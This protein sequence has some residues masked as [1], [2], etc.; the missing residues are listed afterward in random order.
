MVIGDESTDIILRELI[1]AVDLDTSIFI[2]EH[3][4]AAVC[5]LD[6]QNLKEIFQQ[7]DL[8]HDGKISVED[9]ILNYRKFQG[10]T[11]INDANKKPTANGSKGKS[12]NESLGKECEKKGERPSPGVPFEENNKKR[13][14]SKN[15]TGK[16]ASSKTTPA[17]AVKC[18]QGTQDDIRKT[19]EY[20]LGQEYLD[21]LYD[22][23]RSRN[24]PML[25]E[26]LES[27]LAATVEGLLQKQSDNEK[28]DTALKRATEK[29]SA[30]A[31][32]LEVEME[33]QVAMLE[34]KIRDEEQKKLEEQKQEAHS[35]MVHAQG[36]LREMER[37]VKD[38]EDHIEAK[39]KEANIPDAI[40][41]EIQ[42][43][44][45][46]N[47]L[48][49][50]KLVEFQTQMAL[51]RTEVAQMKAVYDE[52][53]ERL[54]SERGAVLTCVSEQENLTRQLHLLHEANKRLHDTND[55]LRSAL[56]KRNSTSLGDESSV[57]NFSRNCMQNSFRS[58][59]GVR[60]S[61]NGSISN[62]DTDEDSKTSIPYDD[63]EGNPTKN[64]VNETP[65]LAELMAVDETYAKAKPTSVTSNSI[66]N[67][68]FLE[69]SCKSDK[70]TFIK[71]LEILCETNKRLGE[72][73]DELRDALGLLSGQIR[74]DHEMMRSSSSAGCQSAPVTP[75]RRKQPKTERP[76]ST[77]SPRRAMLNKS[78]YTTASS[79]PDVSTDVTNVNDDDKDNQ[80][81]R[82]T[83]NKKNTIRPI[84]QQHETN[85]KGDH[86]SHSKNRN[87]SSIPLESTTLTFPTNEKSQL[88][89]NSAKIK[90]S[91]KLASSSSHSGSSRVTL[92]SD[93]KPD[94][95]TCRT[96]R[97]SDESQATNERTCDCGNEINGSDISICDFCLDSITSAV[98]EI[99][100]DYASSLSE[101][102]EGSTIYT[103]KDEETDFHHFS[104][105][106]LYHPKR[107]SDRKESSSKHDKSIQ[108]AS[109]TFNE[110]D[111]KNE[112]TGGEAPSQ[113]L[114]QSSANSTKSVT[115]QKRGN[116]GPNL[117][118]YS[119]MIDS[120][121]DT[122]KERTD[123]D[124]VN[125]S[126]N[127]IDINPDIDK[128]NAYSSTAIIDSGFYLSNTTDNPS[129]S[130]TKGNERS[131]KQSIKTNSV[132]TNSISKSDSRGELDKC[133]KSKNNSESLGDANFHIATRTNILPD[134]E[135]S[136]SKRDTLQ[137]VGTLDYDNSTKGSSDIS[138]NM[139]AFVPDTR[140]VQSN[141]L[142]HHS[143]D[144]SNISQSTQ[145][146]DDKFDKEIIQT[147]SQEED[148]ILVKDNETLNNK[149]SE[150]VKFVLRISLSENDIRNIGNAGP[151]NDN[152][153]N[154]PPSHVAI[155][156]MPATFLQ[157]NNSTEKQNLD[158]VSNYKSP[159]ASQN[160]HIDEVSESL[161]EKS[162][163]YK[164]KEETFSESSFSNNEA[165]QCK[166]IL[167]SP[168]SSE[169]DTSGHL[170]GQ[171]SS[172]ICICNGN[173]GN[174]SRVM[175]RQLAEST[176]LT[177]S[178]DDSNWYSD[179]VATQSVIRK[180]INPIYS[181]SQDATY[182][183]ENLLTEKEP[184]D[185]NND[186]YNS[187]TISNTIEAELNMY[188][189]RQPDEFVDEDDMDDEEL[190]R[191]V[192]QT[193]EDDSASFTEKSYHMEKKLKREPMGHR[194]P[195]VGADTSDDSISNVGTPDRMYK[196]VLAGNAAVGK[197]SFIIRL[198]RNK[199]YSALNSTL[200]VDFQ[201]R[202]IDVDGS[203]VAL[204][205]W[206][207]AGQERFRSI[208]KSYF[209]R[210][211]GVILLYDV[212]CENSFVDVRVWLESIES[213]NSREVPVIICGNKTDLRG[214]A[215]RNG[216]PVIS[217]QQGLKL[218]Q[219]VSALFIETSAKDGTNI[220]K[221]CV[222]LT[223]KLLNIDNMSKSRAEVTVNL[224]KRQK[225]KTGCCR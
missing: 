20:Y 157:N 110:V 134:R 178:D 156:K 166:K 81:Y 190:V 25:L 77:S 12:E 8:D 206:D 141:I 217:R 200:G 112:K 111:I 171:C 191:L 160:I 128:P 75:M 151:T 131:L 179:Q 202:T 109:S 50:K 97:Q 215:I 177:D 192:D 96:T 51:M 162:I 11:K 201:M 56:D 85:V 66:A 91:G 133:S 43:K 18:Q 138:S 208:A 78:G 183:T 210:V 4:L 182:E 58:D 53:A 219:E 89:N 5:D 172:T 148:E 196:L 147:P 165:S 72:S 129:H 144:F 108:C 93:K 127:P 37:K 214:E 52:Q 84:E 211:D 6:P 102:E 42:N 174:T 45:R 21:D 185:W 143:N 30:I 204:Q 167:K 205:L 15:T 225:T 44:D 47:K 176:I 135:D 155:E 194:R 49:Q 88:S 168:S 38:L 152:S 113:T 101:D 9:F 83:S 132:S 60:R 187:H 170:C 13:V 70:D 33:H 39:N 104:E 159:F 158:E 124:I 175:Y 163:T 105:T 199:F 71:Q 64:S 19:A 22:I 34:E 119:P 116:N 149:S 203:N 68:G 62:N 222:E 136:D 220:Q 54:A 57:G 115:W 154:V 31:L 164:V 26:S 100:T 76:K 216:M 120:T 106:G 122:Q 186:T 48:L 140:E 94:F 145:S 41:E 139:F 198:C 209:R 221:A 65:L 98:D 14:S 74:I 61:A 169:K 35:Q 123:L 103:G 121:Y 213:S 29:N 79:L 40:I 7:L 59:P 181:K 92:I 197:S 55:D 189:R 118:S 63:D 95:H 125:S 137:E 117:T 173:I 180:R 184:S 130:S 16:L 2:N 193:N 67:T 82:K 80:D 107:F 153:L 150:D 73:N 218:A 27:F 86:A 223:R 23:A 87:K 1:E 69:Q 36:E 126:T 146:R 212:T 28:L 3:E 142:R 207:T 99:T 90:P 46:E 17:E 114:S 188:S 195:A 24:D 161:V 10:C 32:E 224:D